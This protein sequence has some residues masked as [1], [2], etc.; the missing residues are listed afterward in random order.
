[1]GKIGS[2]DDVFS[3]A[4]EYRW[5]PLAIYLSEQAM[6]QSINNLALF[7]YFVLAEFSQNIHVDASAI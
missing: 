4:I 2:A 6:K 7:L 3:L 1:M 5:I